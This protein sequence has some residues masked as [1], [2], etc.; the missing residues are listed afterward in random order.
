[1]VVKWKPLLWF[2]KGNKP[3]NPSF[4]LKGTG[5]S[6]HITDLIESKAPDKRFHDFA[7]NPGDAEYI[8]KFLTAHNDLILDPFVGGGSTAVASMNLKRRFVGI[9]IDPTAL[10]RTKAN[11]RVN[12]E[13]SNEGRDTAKV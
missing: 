12:L 4:P 11:L 10:E 13:I 9:D 2:V 6:N 7:Q 3:I 5:K 1:M 8:M